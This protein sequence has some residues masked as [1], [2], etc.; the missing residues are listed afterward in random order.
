MA[1][2]LS[3]GSNSLKNES[4]VPEWCYLDAQE[5]VLPEIS[6][7]VPVSRHRR[8]V[9][10]E[11]V[12]SRKLIASWQK[13]SSA[14]R[15]ARFQPAL[16]PAV[17]GNPGVLPLHPGDPPNHFK[18]C[19]RRRV[20]RPATLSRSSIALLPAEFLNFGS[21]LIRPSAKERTAPRRSENENLPR[22]AATKI[23]I[24]FRYLPENM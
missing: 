17:F 8:A 15:H 7:Q 24:V 18:L 13:L 11:R 20:W 19:R 5:D 16:G 12:S 22:T 6:N 4:Q 23:Y 9:F 1:Q 14:S 10:T 3:Q 2:G 21:T